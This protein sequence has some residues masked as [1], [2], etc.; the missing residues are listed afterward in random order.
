[1]SGLDTSTSFKEASMISFPNLFVHDIFMTAY[2]LF[3]SS[4]TVFF[5]GPPVH[6]KTASWRIIH[7]KVFDLHGVKVDSHTFQAGRAG[8]VMCYQP[9]QCTTVDG[10]N[11]ANQLRLVLFPIIY[12]RFYAGFLPSTVLQGKSLKSAKH[13]LHQV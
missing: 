9:K 10:R 12:P 13:L 2:V 7:S 3:H 5:G 6:Q 8:V 11:P 4:Q 1:M